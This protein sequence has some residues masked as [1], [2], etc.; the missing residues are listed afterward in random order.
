MMGMLASANHLPT[1]AKAGAQL[2]KSSS[3]GQARRCRAHRTWAP[4]FAG[5]E[6]AS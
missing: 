2:R 1:P 5:V 4:A 6:A 3:L